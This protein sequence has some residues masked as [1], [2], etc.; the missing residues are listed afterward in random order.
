VRALGLQALSALI[1]N[2][3]LTSGME[4]EFMLPGASSAL[5]ESA[6]MDFRSGTRL[7]FVHPN[8]MFPIFEKDF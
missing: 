8:S 6:Q 5:C 7:T 1:A 4:A 2:P 3:T